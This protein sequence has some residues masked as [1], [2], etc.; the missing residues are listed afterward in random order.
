MAINYG[1]GKAGQYAK[2]KARQYTNRIVLGLMIGMLIAGFALG[3]VV[4]LTLQG[5]F[6][7][8]QWVRLHI[9]WLLDIVA[10]VIFAAAWWAFRKL[11]KHTDQLAS[12]RVRW[13]IGGHGEALVAYYLR[14]LPD[15]WHL[16]HNVKLSTDGDLDHILVGPGGL[17]CIS[18][19]AYRGS[20][21][22]GADGAYLLN[23]EPIGHVHDAQ[24]LAL[25]FRDRLVGILGGAAW[26]QPVLV[27]PVAYIAF[28][29]FQNAAW[30]LH[31]GNL[32]DVFEKAPVNLK[33]ADI[34]RYAKAIK[35]IVDN[36]PGD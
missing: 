32:P 15:T 1:D 18:T 36:A 24:K 30:V 9:L 34:E 19:K 14:K 23:G 31:E 29:S 13:L 10:V 21:T 8:V 26:V 4:A 17:F 12:E 28:P 25:R 7:P 27:A 3:L 11:D 6:W 2:R 5:M 35:S 16:F 33:P 20:Y 22:V